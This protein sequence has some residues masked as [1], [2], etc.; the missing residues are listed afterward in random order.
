MPNNAASRKKSV[1]RLGGVFG[2]LVGGAVKALQGKSKPAKK[3]KKRRMSRQEQ[4][5]AITK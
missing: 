1:N 5:D 4:L 3:G 2:G